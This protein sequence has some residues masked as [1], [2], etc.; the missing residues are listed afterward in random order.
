MNIRILFAFLAVLLMNTAQGSIEP[1]SGRYVLTE[2]DLTVKIP[3]G[4]LTWDREWR[5]NQWHFNRR[6]ADLEIEFN[7]ADGS[8]R[9]ITRNNDLYEPTGSSSTRFRFGSTMRIRITDSGF[10]WY[11]RQGNWINYDEDGKIVGYGDRNQTSVQL[12]RDSQGRISQVRDHFDR[13][14]LTITYD[15][16]ELREVSDQSGRKVTYQYEDGQLSLVTDARGYDWQF[17][18]SSTGMLTTKTDPLDR[19]TTLS[20]SSDGRVRS[21]ERPGEG[22]TQYTFDYLNAQHLYYLRTTRPGGQVSEAWYNR[23]GEI[24]RRDVNSQT[25][26][27]VEKD[28]RRR[29]H[30]DFNNHATSHHFDEFRNPTGITWPDGSQTVVEYE[31]DFSQ[32]IR[33]INEAGVITRH[34]YDGQGNRTRT[35]EAEGTPLER[36]TEY[37]YDVRGRLDVLRQVGDADTETAETHFDYDNFD[38]LIEVTDPEEGVTA[39]THD[40][41]GNILTRT[42]PLER[43]WSHS[44]DALGNLVLERDP[45]A[46][47]TVYVYDEVGNQVKVVFPDLTETVFVYDSADRLEMVIDA[48][49]GEQIYEYDSAG[50]RIKETDPSGKVTRYEYDAD[51]RLRKIIDEADNETVFHY[52]DGP[53][54][55]HGDRHQPIKIEYPTFERNLQYDRRGRAIAQTDRWLEDAQWREQTS[56]T[57]YDARGH[58][59]RTLDNA[60]R[61]TSYEYDALGRMTAVTDALDQTTEYH[62]DNRNNL[63]GLTDANNNTHRFSFDKAGRKVTEARPMGQTIAYIYDIAGQLTDRIDPMGHRAA[64]DYDDAGR[65]EKVRHYHVNDPD[66]PERTVEFSFDD[67]GRLDGYEDGL[68]SATY[69]YDDLSRKTAETVNY[70]G[71]T[72]THQQTWHANGRQASLT[73]PHGQTYGFNWDDVDRLQSVVIPGEGVIAYSEYDWL[74]PA[75]IQF[76]G[77]TIRTNTFDGLQRLKTIQVANADDEVLM[78]YVYTWD[79]T[80]NITHK[81]TEHGPYLYG[82]DEID[83][84]TEAQYPTFS[85]EAWNYDPLGNRLTDIRTGDEEW[86]YNA[87]NELLDSV[88][89]SH[90]Y[91]ANGSLIAERNPDGSLHRT[92]EYNAETRLSTVRDE[93]GR[94]IAEYLYDPFGRRIKKTVYDPPGQN[95][96]SKWYIYSDQGLMAELDGQGN[97]LDFYLFP[98]GGLWSTDPIL[99]QSGSSY[100]YYQT[101]HL[102][103]P[104]QLIDAAGSVVHLR[105]MRAF[106]EVAQSGMEDRWRFPG[107]LA[108]KETGF[109]YNYFRDY[110]PRR[111]RYYQ[112][113]PIGLQGGSDLYSYV[114]NN[115][116]YYLD[117][118]GLR[119]E[120]CATMRFPVG[121]RREVTRDPLSP[122]GE[123]KRSGESTDGGDGGVFW[124]NVRCLCVRERT[125]EKTTRWYVTYSVGRICRGP[126]GDIDT[127]NWEEEELVRTKTKSERHKDYRWIAGG[128]AMN[129]ASATFLCIDQCDSLN[130]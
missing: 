123:W 68:M 33:E 74:Q 20:Y 83:R 108:S 2:A 126:C 113:D 65:R 56:R 59:I 21:I 122:W 84:L 109:Y 94:L 89:Y 14:V 129:P 30:F 47:E 22:I 4:Q 70:L 98:P 80:G 90:E 39:F 63:I 115:P 119:A 6:W 106:G 55:H 11:D 32:P 1:T 5:N 75:T 19:T 111:G 49:G 48:E 64:Y 114:Y 37:E 104:Q 60:Q 51:R 120:M 73:G 76:P 87:N 9:R 66:T 8:I 67:R 78:D 88:E 17:G 7:A 40:I 41:Q 25:V 24:V 69:T 116:I 13:L 97:Q 15:N 107:Q 91:D 82:Y 95:S 121:A 92:F 100:Y 105:E 50:N 103:T 128:Q 12:I 36:V 18:Y 35:I 27:R 93:N 112:A 77:G 57:F 71:I 38:N 29:V 79:E 26:L 124:L 28:G 130:R 96:E 52:P 16:D 58:E 62:Y 42:D 3:G 61:E 31:H 99:R 86:Q 81:I 110:F 72:R 117:S 46:L 43:T 125:M 85:A 53:G 54:Q 44:Y 127:R 118:L 45:L 102:G 34:E 10:Q 23:K 101:D